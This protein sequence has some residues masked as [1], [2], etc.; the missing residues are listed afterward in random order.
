M[1]KIAILDMNNGVQNE[2]MRCIRKIIDNFSRSS[3]IP[4]DY[5]IFD[6][7]QNNEIPDLGFDAYISTGGPGIPFPEGKPWERGFYSFLDSIHDY[8][9]DRRNKHKKHLF[10]ICHSYQMACYHWQLALVSKRRSSA[11]GVFPAH[12]THYALNEPVFE[13]LHDPF[14][15]IDARD[16]Q[17]TQPSLLAM[18]MM[19]AKIL[20]FEKIRPLVNLERAVMAIRFSPYIIGTQFHPEADAEGMLRHFSDQGKQDLVVKTHG[21]SKYYEMLRHMNHPDK[22]ALTESVILPNFLK[23]AAY[24]KEHGKLLKNNVVQS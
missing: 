18:E 7:R 4:V 3:T 6:V 20:C 2:G 22:I 14:W 10:L 9:L 19:G 1:F 11:F 12:K 5:Q 21:E 16:Y 13:G 23:M 8:N 15:I 24:Y 17:V